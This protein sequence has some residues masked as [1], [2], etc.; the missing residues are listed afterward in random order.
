MLIQLHGSLSLVL[1]LFGLESESICVQ[2]IQ[3]DFVGLV[4]MLL[5]MYLSNWQSYMQPRLDSSLCE[6]SV[7]KSK[8]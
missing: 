5:T 2:I 6:F 7:K 4:S 3:L 1:T 8:C